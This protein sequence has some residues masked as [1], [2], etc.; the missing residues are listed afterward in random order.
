MRIGYSA[1]HFELD[2]SPD[3]T[4]VLKI[5]LKNAQTLPG[6]GVE[7][8]RVSARLMRAGYYERRSQGLGAF[9]GPEKIEMLQWSSVPSTLLRDTRAVR[10]RCASRGVSTDR[11]RVTMNANDCTPTVYVNGIRRTGQIDQVVDP[12]EVFAMET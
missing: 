11:C 3:S 6:V 2:L 5:P 1:V 9:I 12:S 7:G 10:V 4:L 8:E